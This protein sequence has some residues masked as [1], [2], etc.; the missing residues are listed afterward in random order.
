[1]KRRPKPHPLLRMTRGK[2]RALIKRGI[3]PYEKMK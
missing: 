2:A 3:I 1:V